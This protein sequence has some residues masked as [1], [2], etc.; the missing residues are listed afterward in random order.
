MYKYTVSRGRDSDISKIVSNAFFYVCF[1]AGLF[2]AA[3]FCLFRCIVKVETQNI[4]SHEGVCAIWRCE[5]IPMKVCAN[6]VETQNLASPELALR[7]MTAR[8]FADESM[9]K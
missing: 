6:K 7:D 8:M 4:A 5:C 9:Y 2:I 3:S 1:K